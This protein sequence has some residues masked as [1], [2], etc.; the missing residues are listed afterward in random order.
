[1][2]RKTA[3]QAAT[4]EQQENSRR[5]QD[6]EDVKRHAGW[7]R[8]MEYLENRYVE[9]G[10]T[11]CQ[12]LR[13]LAARNARLS[14]IKAI[15]TFVRHDYKLEQALRVEIMKLMQE[16]NEIPDATLPDEFYRF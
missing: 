4:A 9:V 13:E 8:L 3:L 15:F 14:E 16:E 11:E 12:S 7:S 6:W 1:M 5:V 10:T 2:R